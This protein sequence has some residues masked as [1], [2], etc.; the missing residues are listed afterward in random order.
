MVRSARATR[1]Q[2]KSCG[3]DKTHNIAPKKAGE[4]IVLFPIIS[5]GS[6]EPTFMCF[7]RTALRT[8]NLDTE[9]TLENQCCSNSIIVSATSQGHLK[10]DYY[11]LC[12]PFTSYWPF[13]IALREV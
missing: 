12:T 11:P 4:D 6:Y 7:A 13:D 2:K 8:V 3:I 1:T 5:I 10:E 9:Q